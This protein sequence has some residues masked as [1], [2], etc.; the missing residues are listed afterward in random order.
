MSS[1]TPPTSDLGA[2]LQAELKNFQV[3]QDEL[4]K[5]Q[6]S[7]QKLATQLAENDQVKKEMD[8]LPTDAIV[9]KLIGPTLL[10]QD[11]ADAKDV[12][13]KRIEFI[14]S[15]IKRIEART[16]SLGEQIANQRRKVQGLQEV[17]Q[18]QAG[19]RGAH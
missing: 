9:Y 13:G 18:K 8:L 11:K 3:L 5:L 4:Q 10:K 6:G 14:S 17:A 1:N 15:E 2:L 12:V 7:K 19:L 16:K